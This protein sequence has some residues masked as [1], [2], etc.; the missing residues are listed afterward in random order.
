MSARVSP[1][2]FT[3]L[4]MIVSAVLRALATFQIGL[5]QHTLRGA[6]LLDDLETSVGPKQLSKYKDF[7]NHIAALVFAF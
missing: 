1:T 5:L 6:T 7:F 2:F 4:C 3:F